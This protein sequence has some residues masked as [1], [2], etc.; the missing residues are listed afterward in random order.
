MHPSFDVCIFGAGPA[1]TA[2]ALRLADLGMAAIVLERDATKKKWGGESFTGAIREPL[3][4]LGLWEGFCAAGHVAGY[5]QRSTWGAPALTKDSIFSHHGNFWHVDRERFDEDLR[6]ALGARGIPIFHYQVLQELQ[7]TGG[8]NETAPHEEWRLRL[9]PDREFSARYLVDATGRACAL[10]R[11]LGVRPRL[12][13]H[14]IAFTALVPRN[15]NPEL[16]H[17]MVLEATPQGWWYAAPV[18]RG[19]VLAF[20]TDADLAPRE[21]ARS[22]TASPA[23]SAFVEPQ[24]GQ[25]W[26][27]VGDACAAHDPLCGWGVCR[28]ITNG[29][30]AAQAVAA[31][32]TAADHAPL[33]NYFQLC[34]DQFTQYLAGLSKRY[35]YEQ[36]WA[37]SRFWERR[38][39]S[40]TSLA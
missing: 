7:R 20:F 12:Y 24:R 9:D 10:A 5:E 33:E 35:S 36:R 32:L 18:P 31:H 25:G 19:H 1:G 27:P 16:H 15:K 8:R 28:A 2:T 6:R 11:R 26:L 4:A 30:R 21:L 22:M 29:I 3:S 38:T 34:R 37:K 39:K 23:N 40:I 13:D 14:L 17:T